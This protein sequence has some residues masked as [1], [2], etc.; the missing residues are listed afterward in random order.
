METG[1]EQCDLTRLPLTA[2][3]VY[4]FMHLLTEHIVLALEPTDL[5]SK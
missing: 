2:N 3:R 4:N 5:M 1:L